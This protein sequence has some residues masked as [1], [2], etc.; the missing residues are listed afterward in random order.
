V[1][2]LDDILHA[3]TSGDWMVVRDA[4]DRAGD[5]LREKDLDEKAVGD[6]GAAFAELAAHSKW[7]VR[8]AI[9]VAIQHLVHDTFHATLAKLLEDD[10]AYVRDAAE[11]A[12]ARRTELIRADILKEQHGEL[13]ARWLAEIE[14]A[15]GARAR[16][17][18][19]RV[20]ERYVELFVREARHEIVNVIA[21]LDLLVM[22]LASTLEK[23]EIDRKACD[24]DI[25]RARERIR[26]LTAIV[27]SLRDFTAQVHSEF[28]V[29]D[30]R[31]MLEEAVA[32]VREGVG[33]KADRIA[34]TLSVADHLR[35]DAHQHRLLQAFSNVIKN[36][37]E[38]FEGAARGS[39]E[40]QAQRANTDVVISFADNGCGMSEEA[41]RD[42]FRL[43]STSK[44]GGTGFGLPLAK[45]IIENEHQG[46]IEL[47]STKGK[48]TTVRL[49]LP[50][51]QNREE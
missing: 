43:Y 7:E 13:L 44:L 15:Y 16:R 32:L 17:D 28:Q 34:V 39:I 31:A 24:T 47:R 30:V 29:G 12:R 21:T 49:V 25:T 20:A 4:V 40:I 23:P 51:E 18:A 8:K 41:R 45:K 2:G 37:F 50:I 48:G 38:A 19:L 35:I 14:T 22:N 26:L 6:I 36:A 10:N 11:R 1:G 46:S 42:V 33:R 9:A 5:R 3:L 27:D